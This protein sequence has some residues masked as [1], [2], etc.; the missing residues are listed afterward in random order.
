MEKA[1]TLTFTY[2]QGD[3]NKK[4]IQLNLCNVFSIVIFD[5]LYLFA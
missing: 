3:L 1:E 4:E 5:E 2:D